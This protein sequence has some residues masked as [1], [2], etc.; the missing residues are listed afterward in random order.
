M[1]GKKEDTGI[2]VKQELE[3]K[4]SIMRRETGE[5]PA[6]SHMALADAQPL[7]VLAQVNLLRVAKAELDHLKPERVSASRRRGRRLLLTAR[8]RPPNVSLRP[9]L[10]GGVSARG[11]PLLPLRQGACYQERDR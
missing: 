4:V 8:R 10:A 6:N 3:A 2:P 5:H 1:S 7:Y 11:Q 9:H